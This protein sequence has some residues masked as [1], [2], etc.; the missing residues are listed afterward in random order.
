M[1]RHPL[2]PRWTPQGS[3]PVMGPEIIRRAAQGGEKGG[4]VQEEKEE[5][6]QEEKEEKEEDDTQLGLHALLSWA[7]PHSW[8]GVGVSS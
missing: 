4:G 3:I 7:Q 6:E 5:K 8:L 1:L 2:H